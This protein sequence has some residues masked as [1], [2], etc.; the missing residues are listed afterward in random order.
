MIYLRIV[1]YKDI[2]LLKIGYTNN[3]KERD[4]RKIISCKLID[5]IYDYSFLPAH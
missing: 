4:K 1:E 2:T 3:K 5:T